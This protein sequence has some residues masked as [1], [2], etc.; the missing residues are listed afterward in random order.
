MP[1]ESKEVKGSEDINVVN[2]NIII[3]DGFN[4]EEEIGTDVEKKLKF[5]PRPEIKN[6]TEATLIVSEISITEKPLIN[7]ESGLT[8]TWEYAGFSRPA[9]H[10]EFKQVPTSADPY[11]RFCDL[12]ISPFT[13]KDKQGTP[14]SVANITRFY[15]DQYLV[16]RHIANAFVNHPNY[17][18]TIKMPVFNPLLEEVGARIKSITAYY[19]AFIKLFKGKDGKGFKDQINYLKVVRSTSGTF[20]QIPNYVGEGFIVKKIDGRKPTIELKP[21]ESVELIAADPKHKKGF[22]AAT[23]ATSPASSESNS[24]DVQDLLSKYGQ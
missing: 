4:F 2:K 17:D 21:S 9:I 11:E 5:K 16:L 7:P 20:L 24:E 3:E 15:K 13:N 8:E 22:N 1:K 6:L 10:L 23:G 18:A 19:E 14:I 12:Y